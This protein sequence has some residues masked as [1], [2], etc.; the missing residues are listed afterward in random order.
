MFC[1]KCGTQLADGAR[2]CAGCGQALGAPAAEQAQALPPPPVFQP[3]QRASSDLLYPRNP[4]LSPHLCWVNILLCGLAQMIHGQ[5]GKGV[6][7]FIAWFIGVALG[8]IGGL[9]VWIAAM[10]DAYMVGKTLRAGVPVGKWQFFPSA[11]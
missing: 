4:A 10:I 11:Q 5:A 9:I 2:F 3:V 7:I 6:V 1:P 8:G